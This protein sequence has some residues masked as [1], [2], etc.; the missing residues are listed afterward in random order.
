LELK[1]Y[2]LQQF[3]ENHL[4]GAEI[5]TLV[6]NAINSLPERC[7]EIFVLSRLEGLRHKEIAARL[8]IS[9][10]TVEGQINIALKKL[11]AELKDYILLF[12][13]II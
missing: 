7:R 6:T 9:T 5:E 12:I 2:S 10:N 13:F 4:S 8:N 1:L 3:D 11:R